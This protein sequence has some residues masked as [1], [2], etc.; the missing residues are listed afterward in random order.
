MNLCV[1]LYPFYDDFRFHSQRL[2]NTSPR[3]WNEKPHSIPCDLRA[4]KAFMETWRA[5]NQST[6]HILSFPSE[7]WEW[8]I[9][10]LRLESC[11]SGIYPRKTLF[12]L[13]GCRVIVPFSAWLL[14]V[15]ALH[16]SQFA[17]DSL[18]SF[19]FFLRPGPMC[20]SLALNSLAR[21]TWNF[22]STKE[23]VSSGSPLPIFKVSLTTSFK[24]SRTQHHPVSQVELEPYI[25]LLHTLTLITMTYF[26]WWKMISLYL[27][28]VLKK[29]ENIVL[30][31]R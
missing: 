22:W 20:Q 19:L 13:H 9:P 31:P 6:Y 11:K 8:G 25:T 28:N 18:Y 12:L 10:A 4:T 2:V 15:L 3:I 1:C 21:M 5:E 27:C 7:I 23:A 24:W 26:D 17:W 14:S 29:L 30:I 16:R